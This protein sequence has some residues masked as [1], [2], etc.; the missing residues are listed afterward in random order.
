MTSGAASS[1]PAARA[2]NSYDVPRSPPGTHRDRLLARIH[3]QTSGLFSA[4]GSGWSGHVEPLGPASVTRAR[5]VVLP[6]V[7]AWVVEAGRGDK[8][9]CS[10]AASS[11]ASASLAARFGPTS[12]RSLAVLRTSLRLRAHRT[13]QPRGATVGGGARGWT[14]RVPGRGDGAGGGRSGALRAGV[15]PGL[16]PA[17][18]PASG[19]GAR[20]R[21]SGRRVDGT[22]ATWIRVRSRGPDRGGRDPGGTVGAVGPTGDPASDDGGPARAGNG[23]AARGR[24]APDQARQA[25]GPRAGRTSRPRRRGPLA[26]RARRAPRMSTTGSAGARPPGAAAYG[27]GHVLPRLLLGAVEGG[28]SRSTAS[29]MPGRRT[30]SPT[31]SGRTPSPCSGDTV[32]RLPLLGLRF[33]PDEF[34]AQIDEAL[35]EAGCLST[36]RQA[37]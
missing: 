33:V 5:Y 37:A 9:V 28:R 16:G 10:R 2:T 7:A 36:L 25:T 18:E 13:P 27:V 12:G 3:R 4:S 30:S 34:F 20:P 31:R 26:R 23:R 35:R 14:A 19:T 22:P 24:A 8:P 6:L 29:S 15:D 1:E 21:T 17:A 11:T 32:L